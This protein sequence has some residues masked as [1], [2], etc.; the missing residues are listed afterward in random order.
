M[1][2]HASPCSSKNEV[3]GVVGGFLSLKITAPPVEGKANKA[4]IELLAD[5]FKIGKSHFKIMQ[6][7]KS[8]NKII[9]VINLSDKEIEAFSKQAE[10]LL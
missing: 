7:E 1:K 6:G 5:Y 4:C 3:Q 10:N 2:I 8:K 9:R